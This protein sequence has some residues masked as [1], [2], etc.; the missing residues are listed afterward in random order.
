MFKLNSQSTHHARTKVQRIATKKIIKRNMFGQFTP[1]FCKNN[2]KVNAFTE[3]VVTASYYVGKYVTAFV[4][5]YTSLN[6]LYYRRLR[7][8]LEDDDKHNPKK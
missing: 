6:Y 2:L 1:R 8:D 5:F 4:F 3:D 7:K